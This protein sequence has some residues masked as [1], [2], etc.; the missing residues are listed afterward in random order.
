MSDYE[1]LS[2]MEQWEDG[3]SAGSSGYLRTSNPHPLGSDEYRAWDLGWT[4]EHEQNQIALK[5]CR[6]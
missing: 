6:P 3:V 1:K 5:P 4:E 2:N